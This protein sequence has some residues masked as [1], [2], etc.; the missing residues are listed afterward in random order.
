MAYA[1]VGEE[2]GGWE[3]FLAG[4]RP[5][6]IKIHKSWKVLDVGSGH[7]PHIRANVLLDKYAGESQERSGRSVQK[8]RGKELVIGDVQKMPFKDNEFDFI[9]ASHIAEHVTSPKAFC[10][11]MMRVGK[12]GYIETPG[13]LGD[14]ILSEVFHRW[15]VSK[16]GSNTLVF[17]KIRRYNSFGIFGKMLYGFMYFN[18]DRVKHWTFK[19]KNPLIKK[20]FFKFS[21]GVIMRFWRSPLF[22]NRGYTDF[23]WKGRFN[24]VVDD[25]GFDKR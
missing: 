7:S 21:R 2:A 14:Q 18:E 1:K 16:L 3:V 8:V 23:Q 13:K 6:K 19:T 12:A 25:Q 4:Y 20:I 24:Y 9:I 10:E 22:V 17:E 15:Y 11:E 5:S